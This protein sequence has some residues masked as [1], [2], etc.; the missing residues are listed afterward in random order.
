MEARFRIE[1]RIGFGFGGW[2]VGK[3]PRVGKAEREARRVI[4]AMNK[5]RTKGNRKDFFIVRCKIRRRC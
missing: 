3:D 4:I 5:M 2:S 1:D